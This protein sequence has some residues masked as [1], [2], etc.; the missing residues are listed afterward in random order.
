[1]SSL[2]VMHNSRIML[3]EVA[4]KNL[5][6]PWSDVFDSALMKRTVIMF[7][8]LDD[9]WT[10]LSPN[11]RDYRSYRGSNYENEQFYGGRSVLFSVPETMFEEKMSGVDLQLY[12]YKGVS[13]YFELEPRRNFGFALVRMDDLFNGIIKDLCE[14]KEL[15]GYFSA[16]LEREPIS[17]STRGTFVLM[18]EDLQATDATIE[19]YIRISYLGKCIITEVHSPTSIQRAFYAREE[20]DDHY[21]YQFRELNTM[22][23]ES[24]CWGSLTIIPPLHPDNLI[25]RCKDLVDKLVGVATQTKKARKR[26][27]DEF[28]LMLRMAHVQK[29]L[30][31]MKEMRK[32][33][34]DVM[35]PA[36][37]KRVCPPSPSPCICPTVCP[38]VCVYT[39]PSVCS[40][41]CQQTTVYCLP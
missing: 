27:R 24:F 15:E 4:V 5:Y 28:D 40:N 25:C 37:T 35:P 23:L 8:M 30:A 39:M 2:I 19:L 11:R 21:Q 3:L 29:L 7:R 14:R 33:R 1:M 13:K 38:P 32:N 10:T 12:V 6:M 9:E 36:E 16:A 26:K 20:T 31:L 41:P 18:D 34:P 22:D 17:R